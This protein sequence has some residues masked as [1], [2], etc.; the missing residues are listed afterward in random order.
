VEITGCAHKERVQVQN[1][2]KRG[3][4][5]TGKVLSEFDGTQTVKGTKKV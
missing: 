1:R 4:G 2:K 5:D 3:I